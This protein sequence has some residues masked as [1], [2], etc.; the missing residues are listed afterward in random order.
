MTRTEALEAL[1]R[2]SGL[3][4]WEAIETDYDSTG[5]VVYEF[6][7]GS[8]VDATARR[9][10]TGD[11]RRPEQPRDAEEIE[12]VLIELGIP[13]RRRVRIRAALAR[14][15]EGPSNGTAWALRTPPGANPWLIAREAGLP[16]RMGLLAAAHA[17]EYALWILSWWLLGQ[18]ALEGRFDAGWLA[19]WALLLFTT[20]P[21]RAVTSWLQGVVA[22]TAGGLL[23]ERLLVG[24]LR[25]DAEQVRK[26][27]AGQLLGRVIESEALESLALSGG[28]LALIASI[29]LIASVIV[30]FAG[31]GGAVHAAL[32]VVW[33]GFIIVL[34]W[35]YYRSNREWAAGRLGLTHDLVERMEGHRTR[36]A[37]E[38]R[39]KWHAEEDSA[40][41]GYLGRARTMDGRAAWL[42]ALAPRGWL[43]AG[44]LGIAPAFVSGS[45]SP[46]SLA[47]AIGGM[48]L[49][50]R[51]LQ[52][53]T[54]GLW[55][56]SGAVIAWKLVAPIFH[57]AQRSD[58]AK[59]VGRLAAPLNPDPI[60]DAHEL[61]FRYPGRA[62]PVL[63]GCTLRVRPGDRLVLQ[64]ASGCGK[65][66]FGSLLAGLREP[67]SGLVLAAGLDRRTLGL[68]GWRRV[69]A[70]APQ[71]HENHVFCGP[72][73]FNLLMGRPGRLSDRDVAEAEEICRELGLGDLLARIPGGIM[74]MVGETGW[75]LSHG[76]RSRLFMARA[77]LQQASSIILDESFA[78]LDPESLQ[79]ALECLRKRAPAAL[80]IAHP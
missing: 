51:A 66:T 37:Q 10:G 70:C 16:W 23:K 25:L 5:P 19:G 13:K 75:Q 71:F 61:A 15:V 41:D 76:E 33:I 20:I 8:I 46:A 30:L 28:F 42:M 3:S 4:A 78:A 24:T 80:V 79:L 68:E 32:L 29:E 22:I 52:R 47:V 39:A 1:A 12:R 7:D 9:N 31:A 77:L 74:Q 73:A 6:V 44:L 69:V 59:A 64:G 14:E 55:N 45:G 18:G 50:W 62:D 26:E 72:F 58:G 43:I 2:E 49:A 60:L 21:L 63:R 56:L 34:A 57:A 40:V 11:T 65:S 36:L 48:L 54:T 38:D 67:D 53:L 27:G 17:A 35:R